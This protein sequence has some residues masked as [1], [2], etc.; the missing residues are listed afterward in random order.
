MKK[1]Y[2]SEAWFNDKVLYN[3]ISLKDAL[4]LSITEP[5]EKKLVLTLFVLGKSSLLLSGRKVGGVY[6]TF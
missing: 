1:K 2:D 4:R 6:S 5:L 3:Q